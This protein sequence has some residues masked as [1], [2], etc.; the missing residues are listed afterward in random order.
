MIVPPTPS[1]S[2]S[3]S[4]YVTCY[5][6]GTLDVL[7]IVISCYLASDNGLGMSWHIPAQDLHILLVM[8]LDYPRL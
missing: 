3:S 7:Q 4:Q 5:V 6:L 1:F 2:P 8:S